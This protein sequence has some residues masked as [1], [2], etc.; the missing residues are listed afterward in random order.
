[1]TCFRRFLVL[2]GL[3]ACVALPTLAADVN[4]DDLRAA[5][6]AYWTAMAE[7][8]WQTTYTLERTEDSD[9]SM[10]AIE[11]YELRQSIPRHVKPKIESVDEDGNEG[12]AIVSTAFILPMGP[13][14]VEVPRKYRSRLGAERR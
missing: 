13:S 5:V 12:T 7:E 3:W 2:W 1:M 10:N 11:Y 6:T 8:D 14:A 4:Q 9:A